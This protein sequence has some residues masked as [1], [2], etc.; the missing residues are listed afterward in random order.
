MTDRP[1]KIHRE[2]P[3]SLTQAYTLFGQNSARSAM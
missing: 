1:G 3:A 2:V